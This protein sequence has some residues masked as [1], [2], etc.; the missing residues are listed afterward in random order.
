[1]KGFAM[2]K[3]LFALC[4][5]VALLFLAP[6]HAQWMPGTVLTNPGAGTVAI[7][8]GAEPADT[9]IVIQ[10]IM[11]ASVNTLFSLE[12]RNVGNTTTIKSQFLPVQAFGAWDK[13]FETS[14][15]LLAGERLRIVVVNAITGSA[16]GAIFIQ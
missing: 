3:M 2:K 13:R 6:A 11:A 14:I 4:S 8:L 9:C 15:C 12:H 10:P 16:Q 5:I 1:M 7:D